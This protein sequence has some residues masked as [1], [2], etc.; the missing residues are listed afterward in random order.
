MITEIKSANSVKIGKVFE[1]GRIKV[2][3]SKKEVSEASVMSIKYIEAIESGDYS[4]FPSEGFARAYFIKYQDFLSLSCD[5]PS[6]YDENLRK[7]EIIEKSIT[8]F[9]SSLKPSIK[10]GVVSLVILFIVLKIFFNNHIDNQATVNSIGGEI[11][12]TELKEISTNTN[13]S[14]IDNAIESIEQ[15]E[16]YEQA[17]KKN[18]YIENTLILTFIDECWIEV[19]SGN[20]LVANQLFNSGD[21]YSLDIETPF[22]VVVGNADNVDGTYNGDSIDF[23]T[24]AN[25]LRVNTII[26]NDE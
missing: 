7:S 24:N 2:G 16:V 11:K 9:N 5:F 8:K 17:D 15:I 26:F 1:E 6:I 18:N 25:R 21:V 13:L 20:E 12:N 14:V 23:I 19:Y 10:K 22:K 3:L 4:I